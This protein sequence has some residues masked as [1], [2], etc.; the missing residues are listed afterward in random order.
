MDLIVL[1]SWYVSA[2]NLVQNQQ[3][4]MCAQCEGPRDFLAQ[5]VRAGGT[6]TL[7]RLTLHLHQFWSSLQ[8]WDQI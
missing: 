3:V 8:V 4:S 1:I 2:S 6:C 7:T 5:I